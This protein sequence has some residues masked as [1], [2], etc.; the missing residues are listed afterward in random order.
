LSP[1]AIKTGG[2]RIPFQ[3]SRQQSTAPDEFIAERG[4][5]VVWQ[6]SLICPCMRE[7]GTPDPYCSTCSGRGFFHQEGTTIKAIFT[8]IQGVP[9]FLRPGFWLWGTAY[10]TTTSGV[11]MAFRDRITVSNYLTAYLETRKSS[12]QGRISF[13]YRRPSTIEYLGYLNSSGSIAFLRPGEDYTYSNGVVTLNNQDLANTT[14]TVRYLAPLNYMVV[15]LLHEVRGW[16]DSSGTEINFPNQYLVQRE[17][18]VLEEKKEAT[19]DNG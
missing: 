16:R 6:K 9:Q 12:P 10:M 5:T 1:S 15:N 3:Y 4:I 7:Y 14:F 18:L 8:D 17:D 13:P 11:K 2:I 19:T